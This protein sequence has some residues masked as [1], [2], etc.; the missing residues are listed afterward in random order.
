[1]KNG[2]KFKNESFFVQIPQQKKYLQSWTKIVARI[3]NYSTDD[4]GAAK[5]EEIPKTPQQKVFY[6]FFISKNLI[7]TG[8][9]TAA[10]A[11]V[12]AMLPPALW[13]PTKFMGESGFYDIL[14]VSFFSSKYN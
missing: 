3:G 14:I 12:A 9:S 6:F 2:M 1:M 7:S 13:Y 5:T 10:K 4:S 8:K 11:G